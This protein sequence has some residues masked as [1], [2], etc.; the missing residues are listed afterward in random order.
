MVIIK[1][2]KLIFFKEEPIELIKSIF[3][4]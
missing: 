3:I 4:L 1:P 2:L